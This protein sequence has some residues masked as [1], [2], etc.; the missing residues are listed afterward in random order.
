MP[1]QGCGGTPGEG[2]T[3]MG[4]QSAPVKELR[5]RGGGGGG[6]PSWNAKCRMQLVDARSYYVVLLVVLS[7]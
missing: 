5:E 2:Y 7:S 4:G 1:V 3:G 6:L